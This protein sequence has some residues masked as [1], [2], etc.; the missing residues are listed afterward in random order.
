MSNINDLLKDLDENN[1]TGINIAGDVIGVIADVGGAIGFVQLAVEVIQGFF[2]QDNQLQ[3]LMSAMQAD[4][5][6]L[7]GQIAAS[8]KLQRMRDIDQ[9]INP[10][11]GVFLQLPA[12]L[13][14]NPP[15]SSDFILTQI[16]TCVDSA[17]FFADFDDKWQAVRVD[18]PYYSDAW[19]GSLA[20]SAGADGLVFNYTYTLPQF[21][22]AIYILLA[23]I[24]ALASSSLMDYSAIITKCVNR[25]ETIH[26][27]IITSGIVSMRV[28]SIS[29]VGLIT[30]S[31]DGD[32]PAPSYAL[33]WNIDSF[34]YPYG[35]VE[36]YSGA[37][38]LDSYTAYFGYWGV[39]LSEWWP[40]S[41]QN[42]L[43]LLNFRVVRQMKILYDR[44][45]L[46][47]VRNAILQLSQLIGQT[48]PAVSAY[49]AWPFAEVLSRL[50][51]TLPP[52]SGRP[53][54]T[55][56]WEEP[57]GM[58]VALSTFLLA[59]PPYEAFLIFATDA[60][61]PTYNS[62]TSTISVS[63]IPLPAD[64]FYTFLTGVSLKQTFK[65]VFP[66]FPV[67]PVTPTSPAKPPSTVAP[68]KT[69]PTRGF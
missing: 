46:P 49:S 21:L 26:Q 55:L 12:I 40:P 9:G 66:V 25:L 64:P 8:D 44:I 59:T 68:I 16:Q 24:R 22:R 39:D 14:T 50:S 19:S 51:L 36:I 3:D 18:M 1:T 29:D 41:A 30:G 28:P 47:A 10:A 31:T 38:I 43:T 65:P 62:Q 54:L 37:C 11:V 33:E 32:G 63:P 58:E 67:L 48:A 27:T 42:F 69:L 34:L 23:T 45:G 56:P 17:L 53:I 15:P 4:F 57:P 52:H 60:S 6:Q 2:T 20:P 35:A 13:A 5:T 7:E 61:D